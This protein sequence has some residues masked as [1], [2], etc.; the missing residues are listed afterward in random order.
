MS[1]TLGIGLV[2]L[3]TELG[4]LDPNLAEDSL[5]TQLIQLTNEFFEALSAAERGIQ[6]WKYYKTKNY[7]RLE[8][9]HSSFRK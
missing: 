5:P 9:A 4:C 3:N 1:D 2:A 7:I 6:T 8:N